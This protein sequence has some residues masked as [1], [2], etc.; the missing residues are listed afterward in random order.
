LDRRNKRRR[1]LKAWMISDLSRLIRP[2]PSL[3]KATVGTRAVRK[4]MKARTR[5]IVRSPA[6]TRCEIRNNR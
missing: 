1:K 6:I 2:P 4:T 3:A 5:R